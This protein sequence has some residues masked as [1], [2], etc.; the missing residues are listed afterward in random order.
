MSGHM[1]KMNS[2]L[3]RSN[4]VSFSSPFSVDTSTAALAQSES[5]ALHVRP[6]YLSA[7]GSPCKW[8]SIHVC[9]K[10][11]LGEPGWKEMYYEDKFSAKILLRNSKRR[12]VDEHLLFPF[13]WKSLPS[14]F[15]I[16]RSRLQMLF[17]IKY[18]KE[19]VSS[20]T[21]LMLEC[22]VNRQLVDNS[23][24]PN[25][26]LKLLK[27]IAEEQELDWIRPQLNCY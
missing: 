27:K 20:T 14:N 15:Q 9:P 13:C 26:K 12:D 6:C 19:F 7:I 11:K 17:A 1:N 25:V 3:L 16:S 2:R 18:G 8:R 24:T 10:V 21:E 4:H 23:P 22:G 5:P